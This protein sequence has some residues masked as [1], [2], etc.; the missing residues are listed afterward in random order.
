M[1]NWYDLTFE[2]WQELTFNVFFNFCFCNSSTS[3]H[4]PY[5][6]NNL[7]NNSWFNS[8]NSVALV[9]S[10]GKGLHQHLN[11]GFNLHEIF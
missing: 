2:N 1:F 7:S 4:F 11:H 5:T 6:P 10:I 9:S 3:L 8:F